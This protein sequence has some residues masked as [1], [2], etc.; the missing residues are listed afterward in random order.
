MSASVT[1]SGV[2]EREPEIRYSREG[3]AHTRL[4][5]ATQVEIVEEHDA[6][7][8]ASASYTFDVIARGPLA[9]NIALTLSAGA[10]VLVTGTLEITAWADGSDGETRPVV[11]VAASDVGASLVRATADVTPTGRP[12]S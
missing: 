4:A 9:E 12:S 5:V 11:Q 8:G 6:P 7:V 3:L 10:E 1:I 2:L